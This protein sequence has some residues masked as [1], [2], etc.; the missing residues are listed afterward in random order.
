MKIDPIKI[1]LNHNY[2]PDGNIFFISGNEKTLIDKIKDLLVSNFTRDNSA[3]IQKI[4]N[5][6][7]ID[8]NIGL[9][10]GKTVFII[11]EAEGL[12]SEYLNLIEKKNDYFI[13][14]SENSPKNN[15]IKKLFLKQKRGFL[16]ECYELDKDSKSK[17]L[18]KFLNDNSIKFDRELF[19]YLIDMLDNKYMLMEKEL[20]KIRE[21]GQSNIKY[22]VLKK[23]VSKDTS[24]DDKIFF[25]LLKNNETIIS[26]YNEKITNS[27]E[28]NKMF[29][30]IKQ[31]T[32]LIIH[33]NNEYDFENSIPK[34][35]FREKHIL[36]SIF[37][38]FNF[39]KKEILINLMFKTESLIR[40]NNN[41]SV[42]MGLR[43]LLN[44]KK[45]ITS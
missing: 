24:L 2:S 21:V 5:I 26:Y 3:D 28:V 30:T 16:I 10:N 45:I 39:K 6:K 1:L 42:V 43:F 20:N 27:A 22:D 14:V 40:K 34:Y 8:Q 11:S 35:L 38:K 9:F 17:I 25:S 7:S 13:F 31:Y 33:H 23:L 15:H 4:K 36:I 12:S 18:N 44:L 37:K 41:L 32:S 19:W 29:F